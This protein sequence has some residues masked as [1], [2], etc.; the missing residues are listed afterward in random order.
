M[1]VSNKLKFRCS[2]LNALIYATLPE[3]FI[4]EARTLKQMIKNMD[5]G[6]LFM[7]L[8]SL[9]FAFMGG[10]AKVVSQVL[11]PVED[12]SRFHRVCRAFSLFLHYGTYSPWRSGHLQ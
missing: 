10:F 12:F 3:K 6:I 4:Y 2:A 9:S 11:P 5:R 8:A 7:L 1:N